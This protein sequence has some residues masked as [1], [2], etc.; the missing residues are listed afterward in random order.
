MGKDIHKLHIRQSADL[1]TTQ[2]TQET[3]YQMNKK[4]PIKK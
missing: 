1:Q 4:N 2:R 3:R